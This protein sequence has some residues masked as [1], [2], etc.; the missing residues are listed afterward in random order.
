MQR[1]RDLGRA[2]IVYARLAWWGLVAP[3]T[4]RRLLLVVQAVVR[5]GPR[6]LLAVRSDLRGWELPGG[7]VEGLEA[8]EAA[9]RR[10]VRE[11]TG[12]E[13]AVVRHVGDYQRTG[14]R[15]HL[16]RV[17]A[18]RV[19]GGRLRTSRETRAVRW[20]DARELP[21]TLFPW[22]RQPLCDADREA[23]PVARRERQGL[24]SI[25]AGLRI[26][27]AMRLRGDLAGL[28]DE[29]AP[30]ANDGGASSEP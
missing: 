10:E 18:C 27:L 8:P 6:V 25:L 7:T 2:G 19:V 3:H 15:P 16:A 20:F 17:Y 14:F 23:T 24:A 29:S 11:E 30:A 22:Y 1:L 21:E 9:L 26:D 12:L 4:E 28:A 5:D 13:V